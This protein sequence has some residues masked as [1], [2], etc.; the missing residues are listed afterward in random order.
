M[1]DF[2]YHLVSIVAV[3]LALAVGVGLGSTALRGPVVSDLGSNVDRLT[4]DNKG[5]RSNVSALQR[6]NGQQ[7]QF[8]ADAAP[9]LLKGLL[10]GQRI[11]VVSLPGASTG[12]RDQI[13]TS[14]G[15][16]GATV[17]SQVTLTKDFTDPQSDDKMSNLAVR[18]LD[19]I[20]GLQLP[21]TTSGLTQ[22]TALLGA[23]LVGSK[24]VTITG[25]TRNAVL[26]S[27]STLGVASTKGAASSRATAVVVISGGAAAGDN[28]TARNKAELTV[29]SEL[30][31]S[32]PNL[33]V[34]GPSSATSGPVQQV[35]GDNALAKSVSTVDDVDQ[36]TGRIAAMLALDEQTAGRSGQY[37]TGSGATALMPS[38]T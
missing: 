21:Q 22:T 29:V 1:I 31:R 38:G 9:R 8:A 12:N 37:G 30:A 26:Q 2:R 23:V 14:A 16:A 19:L 10:S 7:Q 28:A 27:L 33:V 15:Q 3:F 6:Q 13:V 5:L 36:P 35:R 4:K 18:D 24:G 32:S 20:P 17:V 34:A 11:A 25:N